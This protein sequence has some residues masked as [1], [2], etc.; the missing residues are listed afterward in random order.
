MSDE[1]GD[2]PENEGAPLWLALLVIFFIWLSGVI[3]GAYLM[4]WR[5]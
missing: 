1:W 5:P 4:G 2:P 3:T